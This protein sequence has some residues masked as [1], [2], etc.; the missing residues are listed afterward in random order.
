MAQ[1]RSEPGTSRLSVFAN[2]KPRSRFSVSNGVLLGRFRLTAYHS[3]FT[4]PIKLI[5]VAIF[6][7]NANESNLISG[8][9]AQ[10]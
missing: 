9:G 10:L 7:L 8:L 4:S 6:S 3:N 1:R 2:K 5:F